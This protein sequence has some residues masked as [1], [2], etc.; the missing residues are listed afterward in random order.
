MRRYSPRYRKSVISSKLRNRLQ[1]VD[2]N[3][4]IGEIRQSS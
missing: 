4:E 3:E 2:T 1:V